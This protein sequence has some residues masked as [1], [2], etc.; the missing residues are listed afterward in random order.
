MRCVADPFFFTKG[1]S[2]FIND[3]YNGSTDLFR[4]VWSNLFRFENVE[5][6]SYSS[7]STP[8]IR[9]VQGN[10]VEVERKGEERELERE[11]EI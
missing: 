11:R 3:L 7:S 4:W 2:S 9:M 1:W 6:W 8:R 5:S 10:V